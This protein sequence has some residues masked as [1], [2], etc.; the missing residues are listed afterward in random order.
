MKETKNVQFPKELTDLV[1]TEDLKFLGHGKVYGNSDE[2]NNGKEYLLHR[3][4][5]FMQSVL[6]LIVPKEYIEQRN[7][8]AGDEIAFVE[9]PIFG[10][11]TLDIFKIE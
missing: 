5:N 10:R 11:R 8:K 3:D 1:K 6:A 2:N 9:Y 4:I 7:L